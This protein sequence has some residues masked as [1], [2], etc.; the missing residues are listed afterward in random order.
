[1]R[2]TGIGQTSAVG[3]FPSGKS[4][5]GVLDM[6]GNVWEWCSDPG[7]SST[8]YPYQQKP[9]AAEIAGKASSRSLRG[10]AFHNLQRLSRAAYRDYINPHLRLNDVGFR[11]V[12][13]LSGAGS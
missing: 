1:M 5:F 10:G 3:L 7:I 8:P 11:V 13:H 6:C 2:E 9:Y 4:P 12:E